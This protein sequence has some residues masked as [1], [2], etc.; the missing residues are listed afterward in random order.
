[1]RIVSIVVVALCACGTEPPPPIDDN[2]FPI[3]RLVLP[4]I[5]VTGAP[6]DVDAAGSADED[7]GD[8]LAFLFSFGDGTP[9]AADDDGAFSHAWLAPGTFTVTVVVS[10]ARAFQAS[11]EA[12]IVVVDGVAE[13]CSCGA[14]CLDEGVCTGRGC[15]LFS[16]S[17]PEDLP[18]FEDEVVCE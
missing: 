13:G 17:S 6:V 12:T 4:Q 14:P 2:H 16:S 10:D 3:A 7:D 18:A 1:M 15:L 11:A 8:D 5:A 9:E